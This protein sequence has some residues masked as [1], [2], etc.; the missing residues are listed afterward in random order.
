MG[1]NAEKAWRAVAAG[2]VEF[3]P[4]W[5]NFHYLNY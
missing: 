4:V 5:S 1:V 2:N 3:P